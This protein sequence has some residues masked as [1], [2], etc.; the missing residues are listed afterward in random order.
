MG[1]RFSDDSLG[2]LVP[3][4]EFPAIL[5]GGVTPGEA[6]RV[7]GLAVSGKMQLRSKNESSS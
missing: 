6:G 2:G 4:A 1:R 3:G 5:V 7:G